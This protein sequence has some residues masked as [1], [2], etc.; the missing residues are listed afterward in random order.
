MR[1]IPSNKREREEM[2]HRIGV[3]SVDDLFATIPEK[4]R[5]KGALKIPEHLSEVDLIKHMETLAGENATVK[6]LVSFLGAGAYHHYVPAATDHLLSRSEFYSSYTP[7]Q[8]EV[9]QGT[10]QAIYEYQS[11]IC[12]LTGMDVANASLY[13]GGTAVAEAILMASRLSK[14]KKVLVSHLLHPEY[15]QVVRAYIQNLDV[16]LEYIGHGADGRASIE[17]LEE[18]IDENTIAIV[19]QNPNFFGCLE[20]LDEIGKRA[21]AQGI[22][23][24]VVTAEMVSF[25]ALKGPGAFGA[26]IAVGE[27]QS[28]G[29]ALGFG[30]PYLGFMATKEKFI[31]QMP[32][33]LVGETKDIDGK[34]GFVL[35]LSTREQH[36]RREK[37]TSNI[38]TNEGL[39]ALAAAIHMSLLGRKGIREIAF[40]NMRKAAYAKR[41]ISRVKGCSIPF[42]APVFN[43]FIVELPAHAGQCIERMLE[44]GFL[45]GLPVSS[46]FPEKEKWLLFCCTEMNTKEEIDRFTKTLGK[47]I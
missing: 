32:G 13:D 21:S 40:L 2:L 39:C 18:K 17:E 41:E 28:F 43:E 25:G 10:L 44:E 8:P 42:S 1:Y 37:A 11:M 47:I 45:A 27:V 36:I 33:R 35:T 20:K 26:D 46:F 9:S 38:C 4:L 3:K 30:G 31:R 23:F 34:R 7:Y 14:G 24:I 12:M 6:K 22:L 29:N 19:V 16:E 15:I 5:I